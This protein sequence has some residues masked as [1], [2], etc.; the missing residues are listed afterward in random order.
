MNYLVKTQPRRA[1][2]GGEGEPE[3]AVPTPLPSPGLPVFPVP[4]L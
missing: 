2:Q 4:V 3:L 1:G